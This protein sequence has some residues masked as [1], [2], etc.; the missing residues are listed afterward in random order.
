M[1]NDHIVGEI[2][3]GPGW[4]NDPCEHLMLLLEDAHRLIKAFKPGRPSDW[5]L[6]ENWLLRAKQAGVHQ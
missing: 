2:G 1:S 6:R 4:Q 3:F 5:E